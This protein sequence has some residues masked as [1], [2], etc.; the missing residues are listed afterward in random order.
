[1][2]PIS[3]KAASLN[4]TLISPCIVS[5]AVSNSI[6]STTRSFGTSL[7]KRPW[8]GRSARLS[9]PLRSVCRRSTRCGR[10]ALAGV[11]RVHVAHHTRSYLPP[12]HCSHIEER[13]IDLGARCVRVPIH[14][15][16][17]G[18]HSLDAPSAVLV[19]HRGVSVAHHSPACGST[20]RRGPTAFS[21]RTALPGDVQDPTDC[22]AR[23]RSRLHTRG[24][25][26]SAGSRD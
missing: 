4:V 25:R 19:Q 7:T 13:S 1:V 12:R 6:T 5:L 16:G 21:R 11:E 17:R 15:R 22:A 2:S 20:R 26:P 24:S 3:T 8:Y 23:P 18:R 10:T 9:C 14:G